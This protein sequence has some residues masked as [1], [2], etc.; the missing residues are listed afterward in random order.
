MLIGVINV[1]NW[2]RDDFGFSLPLID[3]FVSLIEQQAEDSIHK[4]KTEKQS[5]VAVEDLG[6][7]YGIHGEIVET[8]LGLDSTSYSF[9]TVFEEYFPSLQRRSA[10]LT[11][12]G[13][14]EYE[15]HKLCVL[16]QHDRKL[17]LGPYDLYGRGIEQSINY[18]EKVIGLKLDKKS[19]EWK[20]VTYVREIRNL[21][22]HRD[23][24]VRD[25]QGKIYPAYK[26]ALANLHHLNSKGGEIVLEKGFVSQAVD[27]F[28]TYFKLIDDSIQENEKHRKQAIVK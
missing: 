7:D 19:D 13:F 27:T 10:L 28:R 25:A 22:I 12:C 5:E 26:D 1:L 16:F 14:F 4:Y 20:A 8:Y 21:I 23:G 17:R 24:R 2:Y 18:L 15:L 11:V 9:E 6:E 3:S